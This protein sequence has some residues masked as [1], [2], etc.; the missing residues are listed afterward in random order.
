MRSNPGPPRASERT[1]ARAGRAAYVCQPGDEDEG[2]RRVWPGQLE[3][4]LAYLAE[5][6]DHF[7]RGGAV[8]LLPN[9]LQLRW[10]H[11]HRDNSYRFS[12]PSLPPAPPKCPFYLHS[13]QPIGRGGSRSPYPSPQLYRFGRRIC[14]E[15]SAATCG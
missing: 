11:V 6:G 3:P 10:K 8:L 14:R 5:G 13:T 9:G 12:V 1:C 15:R 4:D 2:P 7:H